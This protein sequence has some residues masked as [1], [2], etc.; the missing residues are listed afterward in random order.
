MMCHRAIEACGFGIFPR[1]VRRGACCPLRKSERAGPTE[2]PPPP[3]LRGPRPETDWN[4]LLAP[5]RT[6]DH[7]PAGLLP[8]SGGLYKQ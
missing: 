1:S 3:T 4:F 7:G 8:P 2:N 5:H 6:A